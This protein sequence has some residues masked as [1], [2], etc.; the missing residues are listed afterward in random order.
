MYEDELARV[1]LFADL[2]KQEL[3]RIGASVRKQDY[4]A[5]APLVWQGTPGAG[6]FIITDGK[7]RVVQQ[8]DD[9]DIHEL[10]VLGAGDTLGEMALLDE[11]PRSGTALT[12]E[13]TT[14]LVVPV[15]DFRAVLR[16]NPDII[17]KLLA[18][19][20]VRL[21]NAEQQVDEQTAQTSAI[22]SV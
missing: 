15:W 18:E 4:P 19:M 14:A 17:L 1:P 2:T 6:F 3:Q 16:E 12:V 20:S 21:R 10:A 13:P 8:R 9:G 5:G 7:V 22:S 11:Q